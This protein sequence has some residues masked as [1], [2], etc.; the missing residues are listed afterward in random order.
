MADFSA[1]QQT[2]SDPDN[3]GTCS[4]NTWLCLI[5][6]IPGWFNFACGANYP[7]PGAK[8]GISQRREAEFLRKSVPKPWRTT[9]RGHLH[10]PK[11]RARPN[12]SNS[13]R[14]LTLNQ[15]RILFFAGYRKPLRFS[16]SLA[17]ELALVNSAQ[18]D[19]ALLLI[20]PSIVYGFAYIALRPCSCPAKKLIYYH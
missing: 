9:K 11:P 18:C 4:T 20:A 2:K 15:P 17:D 1:R 6:L 14:R 19:A 8:G 12:T 16:Y 7:A 13:K 3:P 10:G 5:N